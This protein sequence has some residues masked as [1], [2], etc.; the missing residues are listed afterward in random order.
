MPRTRAQNV[1]QD[2]VA[3]GIDGFSPDDEKRWRGEEKRQRKEEAGRGAQTQA[4][5]RCASSHPPSK[6]KEVCSTTSTGRLRYKR[7]L[8]IFLPGPF[9]WHTGPSSQAFSFCFQRTY[10]LV[11]FSESKSPPGLRVATWQAARFLVASRRVAA[12]SASTRSESRL[13]HHPKP[14][15]AN[16]RRD[17]RW[18]RGLTCWSRPP[19]GSLYSL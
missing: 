6:A 8:S 4:D 3:R 17:Q 1:T 12:L 14:K 7:A 16:I 5:G 13:L 9:L 10:A 18:P 19:G 2:Q 11:A 15:H